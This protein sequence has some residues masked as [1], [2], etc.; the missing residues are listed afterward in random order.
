MKIKEPYIAPTTTFDVIIEEGMLLEGSFGAGG[1]DITD[2]NEDQNPFAGGGS[3]AR[4]ESSFDY[5]NFDVS[6]D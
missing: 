6:W 5:S 4:D 1:D 2:V 3:G